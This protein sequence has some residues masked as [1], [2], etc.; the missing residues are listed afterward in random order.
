MIKKTAITLAIC[1]ALFAVALTALI[2]SSGFPYEYMDLNDD[3]FVSPLEA[4][5]TLD[6]GVRNVSRDGRD[7]AEVFTLKDGMPVKQICPEI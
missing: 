4:I 7:C 2:Q 1:A 6:L 5:Q 3:G